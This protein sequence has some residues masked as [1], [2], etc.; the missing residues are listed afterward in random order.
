M[1]RQP[2]PSSPLSDETFYAGL[3]KKRVG[4]AALFTD[5]ARKRILIVD[6]VYK[7]N[8]ELPGG[9]VELGES[10]RD[11]CEREVREELGWSVSVGRLLCFDY[12]L[13]GGIRPDGVMLVYDGGV[14]DDETV[15]TAVLPADELSSCALVGRDEAGM[16]LV[17]RV[18]RR[19]LAALGALIDGTVAELEDGYPCRPPTGRP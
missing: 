14:V 10:P 9:L 12:V 3:P 17:P 6:P 8:C 18:G 19:A 7:A 13:A 5:A 11:G 15:A 4:A 16:Q 2:T 1:P